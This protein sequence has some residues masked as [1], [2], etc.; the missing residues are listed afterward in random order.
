MNRRELAK[1]LQARLLYD[2]DPSDPVFS[3]FIFADE[4]HQLN[5]GLIG[6]KSRQGLAKPRH[7][8]GEGAWKPS[9]T[10]PTQWW[11]A[12]VAELSTPTRSCGRLAFGAVQVPRTLQPLELPAV[13]GL[14]ER[15]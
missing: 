11:L 9:L 6:E 12:L 8:P 3:S 4:T 5:F 7:G 1:P 2:G 10:A 15:R 14:I 13:T